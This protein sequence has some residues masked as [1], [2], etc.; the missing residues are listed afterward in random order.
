[1]KNIPLTPA[2]GGGV[3]IDQSSLQAAD[4]IV[5]GGNGI[6]SLMIK[7]AQSWGKRISYVSHASLY[8]GHGGVIE[9]VGDDYKN[10]KNQGGVRN[11]S[12]SNA[13]ADDTLAV[14]Y[15]HFQM[16]T[17]NTAMSM[18]IINFAMNQ[19]H[20]SYDTAGAA[21]AG[22]NRPSGFGFCVEVVGPVVGVPAAVVDC[23]VARAAL[24]PDE[25]KFYCSELVVA[26]YKAGGL[27]LISGSAASSIPEDLVVAYSDGIL[28]YVGHLIS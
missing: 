7:R 13:L 14:A 4:I 27:S 11:I 3:C 1:M 15:R 28:R 10:G 2:S 23:A 9:A 16:L 19:V 24:K 22:L 12:L 5:S 21:A 18:R 25:R 26:A 17:P 6:K 20:K 8:D